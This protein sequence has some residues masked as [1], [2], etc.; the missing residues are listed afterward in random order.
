MHPTIHTVLILSTFT[1]GALAIIFAAIHWRNEAQAMLRRLKAYR[2]AIDE[3][4]MWL[5]EW[6]DIVQALQNAQAMGEGKHLHDKLSRG[7]GLHLTPRALRDLLRMQQQSPTLT[8]LAHPGPRNA[9]TFARQQVDATM[10]AAI[11]P[12]GPT[13]PADLCN[14]MPAVRRIA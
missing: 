12:Y 8:V 3:H 13:R 7:D 11:D 2:T 14:T 1:V 4:A 6:P 5:G 10:R 9:R